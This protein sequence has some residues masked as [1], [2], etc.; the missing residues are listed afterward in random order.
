[1]PLFD[2]RGL[3][4][5]N[6]RKRCLYTWAE[7]FREHALPILRRIEPEFADLFDPEIGR[8]NRPVE[9]VVGILILKEI[10]DLTDDEALDAVEWNVLWSWAFQREPEEM[11][12]CQKTLHNFRTGLLRR[13]KAKLAFRRVT[14]ELIAALGVKVTRQRLDSTQILS[15]I[16]VLSRLGVLCETLRVFLR[17]VKDTAPKAYESLPTGI[18]RRHGEES[19]Y[20]DARRE[21]GPRRLQ[22]V[23]RDIWRLIVRFEDDRRITTTEAWT[24]LKRIFDEQCVLTTPDST[25]TPDDDDHGEGSVPVTLK[26]PKKVRS[27]SLQTPHD[28]DVTYS[29]HKGKGY[30]V[31]VAETCVENNPVQL[32]TEVQVTPACEG[33]ARATVPVVQALDAAHAHPEEMVADTSYS[34]APNAS[35]L[36]ALGVNLTAPAPAQGKP[37]PGKPYPEPAATCPVDLPGAGEWLKR[38]EASQRFKQKYAIRAGIE[39]TNSELK[40]PHGMR[41]LRVRREARVRLA[42]YFKALACN[43]KRALR[44]WVA[45]LKAAEGCAAHG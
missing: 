16:A 21:D 18:L 35:Q 15:N 3:L 13:D 37:E 14:D 22:V 31:Q 9:L 2:A 34:G 25:P 27:D 20:A 26:E 44:H 7:P 5:P 42:V 17:A 24:L 32:I 33:D 12:L 28:P 38:Q 29:G 36:A 41:K 11:H 1:M 4:P 6:K 30:A 19:A 8:P 23:A 43:L 10:S 39:A 45:L 40:R